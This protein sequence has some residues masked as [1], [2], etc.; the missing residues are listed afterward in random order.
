MR[1]NSIIDFYDLI[2]KVDFYNLMLKIGYLSLYII[3]MIYRMDY[4]LSLLGSQYVR[5]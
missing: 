2:N 1:N 5:G 4:W 3:L